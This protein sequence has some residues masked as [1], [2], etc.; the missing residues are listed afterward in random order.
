[1]TDIPQNFE[2]SDDNEEAGIPT[3]E[4]GPADSRGAKY[5]RLERQKASKTAYT[6]CVDENGRKID[7]LKDLKSESF[8]Y[9][10]SKSL[11]ENRIPNMDIIPYLDVYYSLWNPA[12]TYFA[13]I[14]IVNVLILATSDAEVGIH[15]GYFM[16]HA[17][18]MCLWNILPT[19]VLRNEVIH[20]YLHVAGLAFTKVIPIHYRGYVI[21]YLLYL[22][23]VHA[24]GGISTFLWLVYGCYL[25][26]DDELSPP[27][28]V[29]LV[30]CAVAMLAVSTVA[31]FPPV[32]FYL[33]DGFECGH[34]YFGWTSLGL[35][36][37]IIFYTYS[38]EVNVDPK[39]FSLSY[40]YN[41]L[42][43]TRMFRNPEI[44]ILM[45][46]TFLIILPWLE[47]VKEKCRIVCPSDKVAV[48]YFDGFV[49]AG[50]FK[51]ISHNP[52]IDT[53]AF[54]ISSDKD[55]TEHFLICG[56]VGD[57]T[58]SL[59]AKPPPEY[60]YTR[61]FKFTGLPRMIESY[62]RALIVC[63]GAGVAVPVGAIWQGL[64]PD[65]DGY[66]IRLFWIASNVEV[67]FGDE[68]SKA[69]LGTGRAELYDTQK[70][71]RPKNMVQ[72]IVERYNKFQAQAI[73]ITANP[74]VTGM[75]MK[76]LSIR[77]IWAFGPVFDS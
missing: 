8:R 60:L 12:R 43:V 4:G 29:K 69:L 41:H 3:P 49:P 35:L 7:F 32:R 11:K 65:S 5:G 61:H 9:K 54:A 72:M 22:G 62:K 16:S 74:D 21:D 47:T 33:H 64:Y 75:L 6:D 50:H 38:V 58:K 53:H 13:I 17:L 70:N 48:V 40:S 57:F 1:M 2:I 66:C 14:I 27:F 31:A 44:Y 67:T 24:A 73:F 77:G 71:G 68:W 45:L 51:R 30:K 52:F 56:A 18:R 39:D 59:H 26:M 63:T 36:W 37:A 42:D 55:S 34:R 76:E 10:S 25:L 28:I 19:V 20:Y 46:V 15:N 23:G